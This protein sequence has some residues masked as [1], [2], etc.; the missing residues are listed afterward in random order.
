MDKEADT[1]GWS[2][3][4]TVAKCIRSL[5]NPGV[6]EWE[7]CEENAGEEKEIKWVVEK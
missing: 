7:Q 5:E 6:G 2:P 3:A 4:R 1:T